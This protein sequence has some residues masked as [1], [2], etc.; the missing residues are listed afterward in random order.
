M[1]SCSISVR[2]YQML[3]KDKDS[4]IPKAGKVDVIVRP[5]RD[6][7]LKTFTFSQTEI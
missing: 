6:T 5:C 7:M 4:V 2:A 3:R 1:I